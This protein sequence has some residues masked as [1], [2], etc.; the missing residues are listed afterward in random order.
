MGNPP[1]IEQLVYSLIALAVESATL[2]FFIVMT[3]LTWRQIRATWRRGLLGGLLLLVLS[4]PMAVLEII[5]LDVSRLA[6]GIPPE[7]EGLLRV[8]VGVLT[9]VILIAIVPLRVMYYHVASAEWGRVRGSMA[10]GLAGPIVTRR[11]GIAVGVAAGLAAVALTMVAF[12]L[13]DIH[14]GEAIRQVEKMFPNMD[15]TPGFWNATATLGFVSV[16]AIVEELIFRGGILG[17]LLRISGNRPVLAWVFIS[18]VALFWALLHI[19]NTDQP[20]AKVAQIFLFGLVLAQIIHGVSETT[21]S[22][23]R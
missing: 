5:Y 11:L 17:F 22:F 19:P 8:G 3:C 4:I 9:A 16:A 10:I 2:A 1:D 6:Q 20:L 7:M 12:H 21:A 15:S 13:L 23:K 14:E 18:A